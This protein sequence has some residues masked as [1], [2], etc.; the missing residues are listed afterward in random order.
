MKLNKLTTNQVARASGFRGQRMEMSNHP[1]TAIARA[2][3]I[4]AEARNCVDC[5][6]LAAETLDEKTDPIQY[7]ANIA[8][9]KIDEAMSMLDAAKGDMGVCKNV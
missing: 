8:S 7:V 5:I 3:D 4:L 6:W 9:G 2:E 1:N